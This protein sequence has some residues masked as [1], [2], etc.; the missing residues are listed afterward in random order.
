MMNKFS[1]LICLIGILTAV[2]LC[3]AQDI[4]RSKSEV[5]HLHTDRMFYQ[6]GDIVWFKLYLTNQSNT[7]ADLSVIAYL[8]LTDPLNNLLIR[9]KLKCTEGAANGQIELPDYLPTGIYTLKPYTLWLKNF[10]PEEQFSKQI[11]IYNTSDPTDPAP[12]I[13]SVKKLYFSTPIEQPAILTIETNK[14]KYGPRERVEVTL[15]AFLNKISVNGNFSISVHELEDTTNIGRLPVTGFQPPKQMPSIQRT[16]SYSKERLI[17][18]PMTASLEPVQNFSKARLDSTR[19]QSNPA[20]RQQIFKNEVKTSYQLNESVE[21]SPLKLPADITYFPSDF[22]GMETLRDFL[23]EVVPQVKVMKRKREGE[24]RIRNSENSQQIFFYWGNPLLILDGY[25]VE[26]TEMFL[27]LEPGKVKSIDVAWKVS[28]IN[29]SA[30][31]S[32]ADNG[33]LAVYTKA[34]MTL[35]GS[36]M[37]Y[38]GFHEPAVFKTTLYNRKTEQGTIPDFRAPLYWNHDVVLNK[39][40]KL[41][42]YTSDEAGQFVI[43]IIGVME[44]GSFVSGRKLIEVEHD[45]K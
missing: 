18:P 45:T 25:I 43:D 38:A 40:A 7:R 19:L 1:C 33:I 14:K 17:F 24:I 13:D 20:Y 31:S 37:L 28:T 2:S 29:F 32:L 4:D 27:N 16:T 10:Y 41:T 11:L 42:F 6:A 26:D 34:G 44:D 21:Y 15:S 12:L 22:E 23:R 3:V 30:V 5:A 39:T 8:E 9:L 35:P 36:R